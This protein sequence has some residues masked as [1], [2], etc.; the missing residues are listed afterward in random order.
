MRELQHCRVR[1]AQAEGI[2][3][4]VREGERSAVA[5]GLVVD[6]AGLAHHHVHVRRGRIVVQVHRLRGVHGIG[7]GAA[8]VAGAHQIHAH[9]QLAARIDPDLFQPEVMHRGRTRAAAHQ[10]GVVAVEAV[11]DPIAGEVAHPEHRVGELA[12]P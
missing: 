6:G 11:V 3:L 1:A 8:A 7:A 4:F 2:G 9:R 10:V 5:A 12:R